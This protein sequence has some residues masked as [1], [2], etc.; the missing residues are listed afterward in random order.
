MVGRPQMA[1]TC[2]YHWAAS[3]GLCFFLL[4]CMLETYA[5]IS[6]F[7]MLSFCSTHHRVHTQD[8]S[9]VLCLALCIMDEPAIALNFRHSSSGL[10]DL[11]PVGPTLSLGKSCLRIVLHCHHGCILLCCLM[12]IMNRPTHGV[13]T[14]VAKNMRCI[15]GITVFPHSCSLLLFR[16]F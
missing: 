3:K 9:R 1:G 10:T 4:L 14:T 15:S 16:N 5:D 13:Q 12:V 11:T 8:F 7:S 2:D 6:L